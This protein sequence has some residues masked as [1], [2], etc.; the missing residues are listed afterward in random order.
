MRR[1]RLEILTLLKCVIYFQEQEQYFSTNRGKLHI[2]KGD[3]NFFSCCR[4]FYYNRKCVF[5]SGI[6]WFERMKTRSKSLFCRC[7][8]LPFLT[9]YCFYVA[10]LQIH[11]GLIFRAWQS[12]FCSRVYVVRVI[13]YERT[14][15]NL[16]SRV[17]YNVSS[18]NFN[19]W[20]NRSFLCTPKLNW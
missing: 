11:E 20:T 3:I 16:S 19:N 2:K 17:I 14:C 10:Q 9:R 15:R 18:G 5:V 4:D 7:S 1:C 12:I 8:G 6:I 13:A